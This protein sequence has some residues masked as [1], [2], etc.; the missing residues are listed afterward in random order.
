MDIKLIIAFIAL[1]LD[2]VAYVPYFRDIF[3]RKTK[4]HLFTWLIWMI[5]QG[6]ATVA[7]IVGGGKFG[8][9]SLIVGTILVFFVFLL[10]FKYGT[11]DVSRSD[12][13]VLAFDYWQL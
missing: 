8:S 10:S 13:F 6:T 7:L 1:S 9:I 12:K 4:P 5:T 2:I 3:A 11:R